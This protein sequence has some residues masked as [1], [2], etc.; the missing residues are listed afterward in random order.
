M[1]YKPFLHGVILLSKLKRIGHLGGK[2]ENLCRFLKAEVTIKKLYEKVHFTY[3]VILSSVLIWPC[4]SDNA[5][6]IMK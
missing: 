2:A 6:L 1:G 4:S 3:L 5:P